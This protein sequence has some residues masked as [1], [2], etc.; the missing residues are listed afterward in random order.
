MSIFG[1]TKGTEFENEIEQLRKREEQGAVMYAA[2]S[3]LANEQGL[4][5]IADVLLKIALDELRHAGLYAILNGQANNDISET[6]KKIQPI[7]TAAEQRI[8]E[9][10]DR[11][12]TI[13]LEVTEAVKS[14]AKDEAGHGE[15]LKNLIVKYEK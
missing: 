6:M 7:E 15:K 2:A 3:Y 14:I 10:A 8:S 9:F 12:K 11:L 5:E 13:G 1:L 4:D